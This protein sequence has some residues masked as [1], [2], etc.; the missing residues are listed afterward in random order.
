MPDTRLYEMS[1]AIAV[2][3]NL[4]RNSKG[5]L[6]PPHYTPDSDTLNILPFR[7]DGGLHFFTTGI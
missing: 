6:S 7:V 2:M 3:D 1:I 4:I 5:M